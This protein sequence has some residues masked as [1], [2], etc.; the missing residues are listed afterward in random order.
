MRASQSQR[1]GRPARH[2]RTTAA[3]PPTGLDPTHPRLA[4]AA[5]DGCTSSIPEYLGLDGAGSRGPRR[6]EILLSI[7]VVPEQGPGDEVASHF[8]SEVSCSG[9]WRRWLQRSRR[10]RAR[11]GGRPHVCPPLRCAAAG[12]LA[13]PTHIVYEAAPAYTPLPPP[14]LS[15][16][17]S[18]PRAARANGDR[19]PPGRGSQF[20]SVPAAASSAATA[21]AAISSDAAS[22]QLVVVVV[23]RPLGRTQSS[24]DE[25][26]AAT[27]VGCRHTVAESDQEGPVLP[28]GSGSARSAD[29]RAMNPRLLA[30]R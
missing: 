4:M 23:L 11:R 25:K 3:S 15:V 24:D 13:G 14:R 22:A 19:V 21:A 2:C 27:S 9:R 5:V 26:R 29:A 28:P 10:A 7:T 16:R 1:E 8:H 12:L 30:A 18:I 17:S 6:R 20:L